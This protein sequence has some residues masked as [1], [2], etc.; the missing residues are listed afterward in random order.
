[1]HKQLLK[2]QLSL[3][4]ICCWYKEIF[5]MKDLMSLSCSLN[6]FSASSNASLLICGVGGACVRL[7]PLRFPLDSDKKNL[8]LEQ[9]QTWSEIP[10][11]CLMW[12]LTRL[13]FL[14]ME[15]M[16]SLEILSMNESS[17]PFLYFTTGNRRGQSW[18]KTKHSNQISWYWSQI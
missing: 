17:S 1:M 5:L 3:T 16:L 8:C 4:L 18:G 11:R 9:K 14:I 6:F 2:W 13:D 7:Q 12:L 10:V 15:C